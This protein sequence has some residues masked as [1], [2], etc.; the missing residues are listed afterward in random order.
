MTQSPLQSCSQHYKL[1]SETLMVE[2][3]MIVFFGKLFDDFEMRLKSF[4]P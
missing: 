3:N 4:I 1:F 2:M